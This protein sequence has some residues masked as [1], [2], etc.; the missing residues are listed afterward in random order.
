MVGHPPAALQQI[1]QFGAVHMAIA[2]V[3]R[4]ADAADLAQ[5]TDHHLDVA[6]VQRYVAGEIEHATARERRQTGI[7]IPAKVA[8]D[9]R[10]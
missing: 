9:L 5:L 3:A 1:L 8:A 10:E 4:L 6:D 2:V 7:P